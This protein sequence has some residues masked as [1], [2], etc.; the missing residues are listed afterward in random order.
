MYNPASGE[1][2][3]TTDANEKSVLSS[4]GWRYESVAFHSGGKVPVYR[5]FNAKAGIGAHLNTA[6]A[7]E[8]QVLQSQGWKYEGIAWYATAAGS[9]A[10]T[11]SGPAARHVLLNTKAQAK[12]DAIDAW[13]QIDKTKLGQAYTAIVNENQKKNGYT[14]TPFS[15]DLQANLQKRADYFWNNNISPYHTN[16]LP[17]A[18]GSLY[19][20]TVGIVNL[21]G[22]PVLDYKYL[23][24]VFYVWATA[25]QADFKQI[26]INPSHGL[27][28]AAPRNISELPDSSPNS[29]AVNMIRKDTNTGISY[30]TYTSELPYIEVA[31]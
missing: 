10:T 7:N 24:Q 26:M 14:V 4:Q 23:A 27:G 20:G 25:N 19:R 1:H 16:S 12:Q 29:A 3:F 18:D 28:V 13:N 17:G 31:H 2:L 22:Q 11:G 15:S 5:M 30:Y 8:K 9:A 6:N 21:T